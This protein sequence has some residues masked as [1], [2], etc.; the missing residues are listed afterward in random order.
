M[1]TI[2][3]TY[4]EYKTQSLDEFAVALSLGAEVLWVDK[5]TDSRFYT[6]G[7]KAE[8]DME[9]T[10]LALASRTL[11]VNAYG[12]CDALRRAKSIVHRREPLTLT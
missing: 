10:M 8:F 1:E 5:T 7:L 3:K 2:E 12:L 6:F 4:Y 9:K 11:T